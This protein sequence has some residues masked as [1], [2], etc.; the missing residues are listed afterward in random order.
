MRRLTA[1]SGMPR[2]LIRL[3]A[4]KEISLA[5]LG[6]LCRRMPKAFRTRGQSFHCDH[7][8][9]GRAGIWAV[10]DRVLELRQLKLSEG[11]AIGQDDVG[12]EPLLERGDS[13]LDRFQLCLDAQC[14]CAPALG[15]VLI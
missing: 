3:P 2:P 4:S 11:L 1:S 6:T 14:K 13:A 7:S 5:D 15:S 9:S 8:I 12:Q 10:F